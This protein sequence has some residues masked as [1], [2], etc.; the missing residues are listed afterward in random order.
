MPRV[1]LA[2]IPVIEGLAATCADLPPGSGSS[3]RRNHVNFGSV[4]HRTGVGEYWVGGRMRVLQGAMH[5][6]RARSRHLR[7]RRSRTR[8]TPAVVS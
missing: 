5:L 8:G 3:T 4:A 6:T 7:P 2:N 1:P